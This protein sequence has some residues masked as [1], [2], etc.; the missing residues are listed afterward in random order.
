LNS[1]LQVWVLFRKELRVEYR[2]KY[3]LGGLFLFSGSTVMLIYFSLLYSQRLSALDSSLWSILFWLV[4]L[5]SAV[6]AVSNAFF[7]ES[8]ALLMQYHFMFSPLVYLW[9][10]I[11]YNT[12]FTLLLTILSSL[13]FFVVVSNP[14]VL[15]GSFVVTASLGAVSYAVLF[16]IM[17]AIAVKARSNNTMVAVL[18]F[19][20]LI[21][22]MI[23]ITKATAGALGDPSLIG[24]TNQNLLLLLSLNVIQIILAIVL[25]PYIWRE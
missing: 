2:N 8:E 15:V 11:L 24:Q 3:V 21:P 6:N 4:V 23:F 14:V 9:A 12:F 20:I 5:F 16:T 7:R 19:P 17:S 22:L 1:F 18:G 10:K 25:F 13:I